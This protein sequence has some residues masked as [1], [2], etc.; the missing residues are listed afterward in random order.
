M[1]LKNDGVSVYYVSLFLPS[2]SNQFVIIKKTY[3]L[4]TI[5][6]IDTY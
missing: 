4:F 3:T 5:S 2:N 1:N 6:L